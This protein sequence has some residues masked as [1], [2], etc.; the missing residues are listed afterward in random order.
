MPAPASNAV[1]GQLCMLQHNRGASGQGRAGQGRA[2]HDHYLV[3]GKFQGV[4]AATA[5]VYDDTRPVA[6]VVM[7][8]AMM[9]LT[10]SA[11]SIQQRCP[12]S[13]RVITGA[14][15]ILRARC[16]ALA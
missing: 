1:R 12:A 3:S 14:C 11:R 4:I 16:S 7:A 13:G 5:S 6:L 8:D 10:T 15:G 2:G 9:P